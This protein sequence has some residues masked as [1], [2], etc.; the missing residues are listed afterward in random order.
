MKG[1]IPVEIKNNHTEYQRYKN[2]T[3]KISIIANIFCNE[4]WNR[5]SFKNYDELY[6][7]ILIRNELVHFKST[8]YYRIIPPNDNYDILKGIPSKV[9]L[10]DIS[11]AWPMRLL[12]KTF[13]SWSYETINLSINFIKNEYN[14]NVLNI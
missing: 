14:K 11:N 8:D 4:K 2:F 12:N 13:A 10:R 9:K 3:E 5:T 6:K 1:K 7:L